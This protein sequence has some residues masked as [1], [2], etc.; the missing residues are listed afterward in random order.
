MS[1]T[2]YIVL[3]MLVMLCVAINIIIGHSSAY[4]EPSRSFSY[5]SYMYILSV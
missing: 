2:D 4:V 1:M 5:A 3:W